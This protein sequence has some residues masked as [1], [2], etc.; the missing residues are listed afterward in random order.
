MEKWNKYEYVCSYCDSLVTY[1]I[2]D[3]VDR[4]DVNPCPICPER[5]TLMSVVDVTIDPITTKKEDK[6]ETLTNPAELST[7]YIP[8]MLV[9]YK[10]IAGT[11]AAPEAPEYVTEKVTD[12]EWQLDQARRSKKAE[13]DSYNREVALEE[14]IKENYLESG[15]QGTL[16]QI[17]ELF[18]I[19]LTKDVEF[20]ATIEVSGTVTVDMTDEDAMQDIL[21]NHLHI[22]SYDGDVDVSDYV[23]INCQ[24]R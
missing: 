23:L 24:E 12:I 15:D 21:E 8:N 6:M 14:I 9:T 19:S 16:L 7:P 10:K 18:N 1:V 22:S 2:K 20:I 17:A 11:Y 13:I 3:Y 5:L 4:D